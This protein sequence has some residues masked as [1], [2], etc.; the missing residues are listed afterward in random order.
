M[1]VVRLVKEDC[2]VLGLQSLRNNVD[3]C[4]RLSAAVTTRCRSC[5]YFSKSKPFS[6]QIGV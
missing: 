1:C 6:T 4:D 3:T 2:V 5:V